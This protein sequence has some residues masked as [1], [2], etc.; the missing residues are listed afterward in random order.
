MKQVMKQVSP[1][2]QTDLSDAQW[3]LVAAVLPSAKNG[4]T[5]RPRKWQARHIWNAIFYQARTGCAWRHLPHDMPP[6]NVVW[7]QFVRW[8]NAGVIEAA[9]DALRAQVR[10]REGRHAIPSACVID[11][12]SVKTMQK[13]APAATTAPK[14]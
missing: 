2:Y 12:Q 3:Q 8:R 7:I 1:G 4:R 10:E 5:G 13:G 6:W 11:S 9:H 14:R